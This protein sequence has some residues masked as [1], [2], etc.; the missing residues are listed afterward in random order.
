M[1]RKQVE[2]IIDKFKSRK[3]NKNDKIKWQ[4]CNDSNKPNNPTDSAHTI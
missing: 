4:K 2:N 1:V 3:W